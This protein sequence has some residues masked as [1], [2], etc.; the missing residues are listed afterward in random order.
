M[1]MILARFVKTDN[2]ENIRPREYSI[3]I[4]IHPTFFIFHR[5]QFATNR[6][7]PNTI[8]KNPM[9]PPITKDNGPNSPPKAAPK[10]IMNIPRTIA[11]MPPIIPRI[12][13]TVIPKGLDEDDEES[14]DF[15]GATEVCVVLYFIR[16]SVRLLF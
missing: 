13:I 7:N 9:S 15:T 12:E 14:A 8:A 3:I 4:I 1:L 2:S 16:K 11:N 5:S 6:I 10:R